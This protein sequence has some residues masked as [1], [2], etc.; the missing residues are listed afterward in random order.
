MWTRYIS[1]SNSFLLIK[2]ITDSKA[3]KFILD[4]LKYQNLVCVTPLDPGVQ[5][6]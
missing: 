4:L 2:Y 3:V 6:L 1:N 5:V